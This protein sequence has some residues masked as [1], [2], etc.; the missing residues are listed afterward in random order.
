MKLF[1]Y[2]FATFVALSCTCAANASEKGS[3]QKKSEDPKTSAY[4]NVM[5]LV[6]D[7]ATQATNAMKGKKT[8]P[9]WDFAVPERCRADPE[10]DQG[11]QAGTRFAW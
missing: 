11:I 10:T 6:I 5:R 7:M 2:L 9:A 8:N 1:S 4:N 3:A